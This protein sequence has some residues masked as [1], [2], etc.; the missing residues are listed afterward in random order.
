[1]TSRDRV[2]KSWL[3]LYP[4][5]ISV[6]TTLIEVTECL[7]DTTADV[8]VK[9]STSLTTIHQSDIYAPAAPLDVDQPPTKWIVIG[10][11]VYVRAVIDNTRHGANVVSS[12][13][14]PAARSNPGLMPG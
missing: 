3:Y 14:K 5:P 7:E 12:V 4:P 2:T 8:Y 11:A 10:V 9:L 13:V 6:N 1:M